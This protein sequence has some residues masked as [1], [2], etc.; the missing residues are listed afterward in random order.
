VGDIVEYGY[1][2]DEGLDSVKWWRG[3]VKKVHNTAK[4][5]LSYDI[6]FPGDGTTQR[7]MRLP[8]ASRV[9]VGG[10]AKEDQWCLVRGDL[11][12]VIEII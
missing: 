12:D 6:H 11:P 5:G 2:D 7:K 9:C 10:R 4:R 1:L 3:T 8:E